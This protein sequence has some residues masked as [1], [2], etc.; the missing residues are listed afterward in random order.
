MYACIHW[1]PEKEA[2]KKEMPEVRRV[3]LQVLWKAYYFFWHYTGWRGV[4]KFLAKVFSFL[5]TLLPVLILL[6]KDGHSISHMLGRLFP[7]IPPVSSI[8]IISR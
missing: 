8:T 1:P 5:L 4:F 3:Y 6:I 7:F 2:V